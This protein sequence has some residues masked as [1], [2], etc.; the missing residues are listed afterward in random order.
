MTTA[1]AH[2]LDSLGL[3]LPAPPVPTGSFELFVLAGSTVHLAGQT[4][5]LNGIPT[6]T[7]RVPRDVSVEEAV[8]AARVCGLNLLASLAQACGGD[9]GR[10]ER[11]V[12]VRGYV[13][14]DDGFAHVPSVING[15]SDLFVEVFGEAGRHA[16]TAIGVAALPKNAVVEVDS[17]FLVRP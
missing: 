17:T 10:V 12:Q 1:W 5:E 4:N 16:R 8:A 3:V 15:A 6:A 7:G 11:C 2:R 9:L 13:N 14:A